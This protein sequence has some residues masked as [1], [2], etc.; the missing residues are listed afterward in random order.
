MIDGI[1]RCEEKYHVRFEEAARLG[2]VRE[3]ETQLLEALDG[4]LPELVESF[5]VDVPP[6]RER[7]GRLALVGE[8]Y[9]WRRTTGTVEARRRALILSYLATETECQGTFRLGSAHLVKVAA[10]YD[11]MGAEFFALKLYVHAA[12]CYQKAADYDMVLSD[13]ARRD[14]CLLR[15]HQARHRARP[16]NLVRALETAS[17]I[18]CGYGYRPFLLLG[19]M[20]GVLAVFCLLVWMFGGIGFGTAVEGSFINFLNP[21]GLGDVNGF[22]VAAKTLFI[23][24]SYVG[25]AAMQVFFVLLVRFLFHM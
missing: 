4:Y 15:Q 24:E 12:T 3:Q 1:A 21:L 11:A 2:D 5:D 7:A 6:P 10:H 20:G 19:W 18:T 8:Y 16:Y 25:I 17:E 14:K 9:A 23:I 22:G 13:H